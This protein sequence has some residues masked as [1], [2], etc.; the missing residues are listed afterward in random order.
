MPE[1]VSGRRLLT[2]VIT[3][4]GF[5]LGFPLSLVRDA[6]AQSVY[7]EGVTPVRDLPRRAWA[8]EI[9]RG[10]GAD[11][12]PAFSKTL[13]LRQAI[14]WALER[15][16]AMKAASIE[17]EARHGEEAQSAV[18]PNPELFVEVENFGGSRDKSGFDATETTLGLAQTIELG[19]KRL[20][21][22]QAA[23][24]DASLAVW[25]YEAARVQLAS[26]VARAFIDVVT[27]QERIDVLREFVAIAGKTQSAVDARVKGGKASPIELDRAVVAKARAGASLKGEEAR[28]NAA[29]RRL[30]IFW[31]AEGI[32]F[33]RAVGRLGV[34]RNAPPL[35]RL[36]SLLDDNP[37]LARWSDEVGRRVAQLDVE[38]GKSIP[39][40][41]IG[42]GLRHFNEDDSVAA[43]ASLSIPLP[44]FDRNDGNIAAAERRIVKAEHQR[45]AVRTE[46]AGALAEAVGELQIATAQLRAFETDV[47]PPAQQAFERTKIGYD[48]GKFDILNV[49]DAQR[50]VF[51]VRLDLLTARADYEKAR[52]KVEA[53]IGR[54]LGGF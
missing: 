22:L 10:P 4:V 21:R 26:K 36:R 41:K 49:L 13:T 5:A 8:V 52:V 6:A 50:S 18:K 47:L 40:V 39:D 30:S 1:F 34:G 23:H 3:L 53:M 27:A 9:R 17:I 15:H 51:E 32:N 46:L 7:A 28:L 11:G 12:P 33:N 31:R 48:E 43:V 19:D 45:E 42:A 2:A 25:D 54:D 37:E 38:I 44:V 35:V 14:K 29:K 16:P 20:R 24:L